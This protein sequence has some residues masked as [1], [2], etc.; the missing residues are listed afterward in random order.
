MEM[1]DPETFDV[2]PDEVDRTIWEKEGGRKGRPVILSGAMYVG[3]TRTRLIDNLVLGDRASLG[4][5][6]D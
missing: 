1:N 3:G 5:L 2:L 6:E 4:V